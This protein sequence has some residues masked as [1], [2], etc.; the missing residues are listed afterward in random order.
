[1]AAP[2]GAVAS[3]AA[4]LVAETFA[5]AFRG[6]TFPSH[7]HAPCWFVSLSLSRPLEAAPATGLRPLHATALLGPCGPRPLEALVVLAT[8]HT[9]SLLRSHFRFSSG[10]SASVVGTGA[11]RRPK[12]FVHDVGGGAEASPQRTPRA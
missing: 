7:F 1:M 12:F 9:C 2:A 11:S 4:L 8:L 10:P 3:G 6:A 5:S